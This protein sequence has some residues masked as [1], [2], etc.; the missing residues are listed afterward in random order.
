MRTRYQIVEHCGSYGRNHYRPLDF[1]CC[2]DIFDLHCLAV[3]SSML[4]NVL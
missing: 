2:A 1:E 3:Q 4:P